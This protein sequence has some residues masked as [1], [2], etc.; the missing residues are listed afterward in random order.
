MTGGRSVDSALDVRALGPS[1]VRSVYERLSKAPDVSALAMGWLHAQEVARPPRGDAFRLGPNGEL[2][3][4]AAYAG[5][6]LVASVLAFGD[7]TLLT[8]GT[9]VAGAA[10]IGH[11]L[12]FARPVPAGLRASP[13]PDPA[14]RGV[15]TVLGA[16]DLTTALTDALELGTPSVTLR[17]RAYLL[18]SPPASAGAVELR[19]ATRGDFAELVSA[20]HAMFAEEIRPAMPVASRLTSLARSV[21]QRIDAGRQWCAHIDG[22]LVF[23]ASMGPCSPEV[24]QLEGVWVPKHLRRR[25][26]GFAMLSEL[27]ARL[28]ESHAA[29]G[30]SVNLD[31]APARELYRR[32]GFS[33]GGPVS[34]LMFD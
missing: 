28:F 22:E 32:L 24:A 29:I 23:K 8:N 4:F 12:T 9:S 5:A 17:Q 7:D 18:R 2:R 19:L 27:C 16:A 30:L 3:L 6:E 1:D 11:R 33:A 20:S 31:N 15:R 26:I 21:D 14:P 25:G 34:T 10:A 13:S